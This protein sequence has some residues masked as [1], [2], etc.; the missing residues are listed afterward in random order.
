MLG[1][2]GVRMGMA[3][4]GE[5]EGQLQ[6]MEEGTTTGMRWRGKGGNG[7]GGGGGGQRRVVEGGSR[8]GRGRRG[9]GRK[10]GG[11]RG[12]GT[13]GGDEDVIAE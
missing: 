10:G 8:T 11:G 6:L 4:V 13:E 3:V 5:E 7:G 12:G 9:Q 2:K 1:G